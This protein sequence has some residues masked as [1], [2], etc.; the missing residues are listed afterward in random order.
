MPP[1]LHSQPP[2]RRSD[3]DAAGDRQAELTGH[4]PPD[5][6]PQLRGMNRGFEKNQRRGIVNQ[7]L[8][9]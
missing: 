8:T 5:V 6:M 2:N 4:R 9:P 7:A 3:Y 1:Q